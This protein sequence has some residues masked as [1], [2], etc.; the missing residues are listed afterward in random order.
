MKSEF[1][2][3]DVESLST[4]LE[5]PPRDVESPLM[6]LEFLLTDVEIL[7][8]EL[9]S[10][11]TEVE[12]LPSSSSSLDLIS[13]NNNLNIKSKIFCYFFVICNSLFVNISSNVSSKEAFL[14]AIVSA[15][16]K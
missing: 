3:T 10:P 5:S 11:L 6:E 1:L 7:L 12:I 9:E 16:V 4:E 13:G 2:L 14:S 15:D 8:T